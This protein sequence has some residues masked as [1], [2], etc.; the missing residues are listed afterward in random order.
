VL[1]PS[2]LGDVR[3]RPLD[4]HAATQLVRPRARAVS[5]PYQ[6]ERRYAYAYSNTRH[7]YFSVAAASC[8]YHQSAVRHGMVYTRIHLS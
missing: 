8:G 6:T 5:H 1:E 2:S 4:I 3:H 7:G